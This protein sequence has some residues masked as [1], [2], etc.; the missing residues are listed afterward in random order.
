MSQA[1]VTYLDYAATS[2]Q[3][4]PEVA[5]AVADYIDR[6]GATPGRGGHRLA[7]AAGRIVLDCRQSLARLLG[8]AGDPGRITFMLNAT[9]AIN[10]ALHGV[11]ERGDVVVISAFDHNAVVRCVHR[12]AGERDVQVRCVPG[13]PDGSLDEAAWTRA[14]DGARMVV[15]NAVSNV[16]GTALDVQ[17]LGAQARA[18]GALVLVDAAQA[19]GHV[20]ADFARDGADLVA[21]SGHKGLLGPQGVGAL[22]VREG[23][24]VR[25]LLAGGT[26]G[27]SMDPDMP[28]AWPDHL[29]A[30]T[31]NGPG[32]AGLR[33]GVRWLLEH[34][35]DTLH[36]RT[37]A[38]ARSLHE[39]L[40]AIPGLRL[41]S[42]PPAGG[43]G[44][45]VS[46]IAHDVDPAA[47]ALRL[48][49]EFGVLVRA[50]LHCAPG[51][52]RMLGTERSGAV[53]MS[54]GWASTERDVER[55]LQGV[56]SIV[57]A[58]R[59]APASRM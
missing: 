38:L 40:T 51:V 49:R 50:G 11:L 57:A 17:R 15:L 29:E 47:L 56:R 13:R 42:P 27:E 9:H 16:L 35:V 7:V 24:E 45:I 2:A 58:P 53:R 46:F 30:G 8:L 18:A 28:R 4:P 12:L 26:G 48:D 52:H 19:A 20:P 23:V 22:W 31:L 36:A 5:R 44:A 34:G 37:S 14:I 41:L 1:E 32:I 54:F 10:T 6:V 3:R 43:A 21:L 25:P 55:A 39:E 59:L 33:A